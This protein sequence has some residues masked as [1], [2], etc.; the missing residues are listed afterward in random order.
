MAVGRKYERDID[1]LLA[2]EFAVS[3]TFASWFL[4]KTRFS[5]L[6]ANVLDVYVSRSDNTGE[7]DPVVVYEAADGG[8]RFALLIEDKIDAPVQPD[9]AARYRL[10]ARAEI[11]RGDYGEFDLVLCSPQAYPSAHPEAAH[12]DRFVS[13]EEICEFLKGHDTSP[14]AVY[15]ANFVAAASQRSSSSWVKTEDTATEHFWRAAYELAAQEY[16]I[17]EMRPRNPG[18]DVTWISIR[19]MIC[20]RCRA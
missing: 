19:R 15:R 1:L 20:Q 17:L 16:P 7:S 8:S 11:S 9:Q 10:R 14:R 12:F 4:N 13:Y 18:K 5:N 2:E 3:P 6:Q